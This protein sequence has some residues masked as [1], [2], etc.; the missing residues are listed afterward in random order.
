MV[1]RKDPL[2]EALRR[3]NPAPDES[4]SGWHASP[5]GM[6]VAARARAEVPERMKGPMR[7]R[8]RRAIVL[9]AAA[10]AVFAV[11]AGFALGSRETLTPDTA[12][13][14]NELRQGPG[15]VLVSVVGRDPID[16]CSDVWER[17]FNEP[18]PPDLVVCVIQEGATGVFPNPD[19][20]TPDQ[21]CSSIGADVLKKP[22]PGSP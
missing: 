2:L 6:E 17:S 22:E 10:A 7:Q 20:M 16:A 18:A 8:R 14:R 4:T 12:L 5:E 1:N 3:A 21:A 19:D 15:G 11:A 9:I 13:C